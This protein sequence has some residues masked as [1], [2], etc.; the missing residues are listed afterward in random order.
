MNDWDFHKA[1]W[2]NQEIEAKRAVDLAKMQ[3][4]YAK[5][6]GVPGFGND[7]SGLCVGPKVSIGVVEHKEN[8]NGS[9]KKSARI[10]AL[11]TRM[12]LVEKRLDNIESKLTNKTNIQRNSSS[13]FYVIQDSTVMCASSPISLTDEQ[14]KIFMD[15]ILKD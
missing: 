15:S 4:E 2:E 1:M 13:P 11:E 10:K 7:D 6:Q 9:G 14:F 3:M 12:D 5:E 8:S